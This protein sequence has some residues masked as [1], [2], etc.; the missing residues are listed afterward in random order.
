MM[1]LDAL[2]AAKTDIAKDTAAEPFGRMTSTAPAGPLWIKWR[3]LDDGFAKDEEAVA[4]CRT[5]ESSC[6]PAAARLVAL[7]DEARTLSGRRRLAIVNRAINL[8]IAYTSDE[9]QFGRGDVWSN[10]VATFTSG[11]GDCEDYA[12]AKMFALRAAG[13][14]AQDM[15]LLVARLR[16][17]E[18]HAVLAVRDDGH[19]LI[20]DNRSMRLVEDTRSSD[21]MPLFALDAGGVREFGGPAP[22][23][24]VAARSPAEPA[25]VQPQ[26]E[27]AAAVGAPAACDFVPASLSVDSLL[28]QSAPARTPSWLSDWF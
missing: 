11:R 23:I 18:A 27:I 5:D 15:R 12:I 13:I 2:A 7:I 28:E 8:S 21:L 3:G 4:Q 24:T 16:G 25:A 20:L 6:A 17:G 19:W 10:P 1:R 22:V 9:W 26:P 14:P